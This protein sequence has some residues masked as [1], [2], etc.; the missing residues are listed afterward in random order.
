MPKQRKSVRVPRVV[1]VVST[2]G[3]YGPSVLRGVFAHVAANG[4]WGLEIIRSA[5]A[6]TVGVVRDALRHKVD[7]FLVALNENPTE[8]FAS[9]ADSNVPFVT[10][11]TYS[12]T[13]EARKAGAAHFRVDN[14]AIGRNA[15]SSFLS[16]GRYGAFGFVGPR[17]EREWSRQREKGFCAELGRHGFVCARFSASVADDSVSL[18][19]DLAKWLRRLA[20]PAAVLAADDPTALDVLQACKVAKLSI[21]SEVAMLGV[22][23]E[24]LL[25]ENSSPTISSIRPDFVGAGTLAARELERLMRHRAAP[26]ASR[27]VS[28]RGVNEIV[29]RQSTSGM[30]TSGHLVQK[31][32]AFIENNARRGIGVKDVQEHLRVSRSLMDL[33]FREVRGESVLSVIVAARLKELKRLLRDTNLPIAE[34]TARLGWESENYPKN[35][36]RRRFGLSMSEWRGRAT[37]NF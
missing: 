4:E 20:K 29:E 1:A 10:V 31:A 32:V 33:R 37:E 35:L 19:G 12:T 26:P 36:F 2:Q 17:S 16:Q 15:A 22:D 25:C 34:I 13:L 8:A 7:G 11:E 5:G 18:R 23:D 21:P 28:V 14:M 27:I 3:N 24:T 9:L 6:F 30:K